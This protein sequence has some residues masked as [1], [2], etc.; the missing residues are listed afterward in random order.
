MKLKALVAALIATSGLLGMSAA[1]ASDGTITFNGSIVA[2]TCTINGGGAA[3]S[4][5]VTLPP[6]DKSALSAAGQTAAPTP[7][8]FNLTTCPATTAVHTLFE[9]G[10]TVDTTTGNLKNS[11]GTAT[12]VQIGLLNP[13]LAAINIATQANDG[14]GTGLTTSAAGA[15]TLTYYAQYVAT[16]AATSGTVATTV[17]YSIVYN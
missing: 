11:T 14:A 5:T 8:T 12:G 16:A 2:T 15:A 10:A 1:Q 13:A 3:S 9:L 4:F 6:V 17:T 7:V